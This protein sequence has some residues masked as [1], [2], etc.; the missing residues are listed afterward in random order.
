MIRIS[1]KFNFAIFTFELVEGT[2]CTCSIRNTQIFF[3][4]NLIKILILIILKHVIFH[5]LLQIKCRKIVNQKFTWLP[6][7]TNTPADPNAVTAHV[8]SVP[9]NACRI[10]CA[11]RIIIEIEIFYLPALLNRPVAATQM[12]KR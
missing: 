11:S 5:N 6:L 9:R 1:K 8:K 12:Q 10:G 2:L 7:R 3:L 4:L